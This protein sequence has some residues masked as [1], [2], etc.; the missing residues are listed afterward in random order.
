MLLVESS[1]EDDGYELVELELDEDAIV[2]YIED[3]DG[4][5][6]GFVLMEDGEEAEYFYVAEDDDDEDSDDEFDFGITKEG[7][8]E[9]TGDMNAIYKDGIAVAAELKGA[10]DDIK[11]ALDFG[12]VLKK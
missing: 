8:A 6:S 10:F 5:R 7:V 1:E 3:D 9:V 2:R 11:S 12:S 4:E